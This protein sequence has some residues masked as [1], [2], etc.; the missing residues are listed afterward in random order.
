[1]LEY[2]ETQNKYEVGEIEGAM[3]LDITKIK[4]T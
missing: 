4:K 3:H 1:M 2:A